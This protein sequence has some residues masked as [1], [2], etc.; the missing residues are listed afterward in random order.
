MNF[1]LDFVRF[2]AAEL[3]IVLV[4]FLAVG[5]L[6]EIPAWW[7]SRKYKD[8]CAEKSIVRRFKQNEARRSR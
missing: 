6:Q 4:L 5:M 7:R 8:R 1:W 3:L 2:Y